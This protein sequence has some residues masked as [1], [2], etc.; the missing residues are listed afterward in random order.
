MLPL[1]ILGRMQKIREISWIVFENLTFLKIFYNVYG[2]RIGRAP[3][4][5]KKIFECR[6]NTAT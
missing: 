4:P 2:I 3:T 5:P 1:G 6:K